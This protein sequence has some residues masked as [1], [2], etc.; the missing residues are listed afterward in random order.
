MD[1]ALTELA[2]LDARQARIVELR[3]FVGLTDREIAAALGLSERTVVRE[4]RTARLWLRRRIR[5]GLRRGWRDERWVRVKHLLNR[6]FDQPPDRRDG[7]LARVCGSDA[8]LRR[9]VE[10]LLAQVNRT[11]GLIAGTGVR[12]G[13]RG[14]MAAADARS[15]SSLATAGRASIP[16]RLAQSL[17]SGS[18]FY[19]GP[20]R[21]P[22]GRWDLEGDPIC[23]RYSRH[24][25]VCRAGR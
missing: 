17:L 12:F 4:W 5:R 8:A 21:A 15:S 10:S 3:F 18:S 14:P 7:F 6:S 19:W 16:H 22:I 11:A 9:D 25:M 2:S 1:G 23:R 20:V 24:R 13:E